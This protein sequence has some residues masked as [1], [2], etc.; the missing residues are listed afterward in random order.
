M[1]LENLYVR[2][3]NE[4]DKLNAMVK[5]IFDK[6]ARLP[7]QVFCQPFN[8]FMFEEFDW[9][10]S[11]DFWNTVKNIA[12]ETKDDFIL[13]AV[14]EPSP[15]EYFYKEFNYFNWVKLPVNLSAD[16]YLEALELGPEESPADAVVYNSYTVIWLS[17]SMKWAIWGERNYGI[18]IIGFNDISY[19]NKLLSSL[20]SWHSLD[21]TVLSWIQSNLISEPHQHNFVEKFRLNYSQEK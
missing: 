10:I 5:S 13:T 19:R 6:E 2:E 14:L 11:G 12:F 8:F 18:S 16:E 4:F 7:E 21:N 3:K 17:P 1:D 9:T 20:Q 15:E